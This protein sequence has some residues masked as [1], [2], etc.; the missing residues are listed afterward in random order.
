[1]KKLASL[2]ILFFIIQC[3]NPQND[4]VVEPVF[5]WTRLIE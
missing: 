4:E 2:L 3:N 1:M 5:N